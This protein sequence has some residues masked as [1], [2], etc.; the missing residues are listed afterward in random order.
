MRHVRSRP[1]RPDDSPR[2][3]RVQAP[4]RAEWTSTVPAGRRTVGSSRARDHHSG[5]PAL[6]VPQEERA[7]RLDLEDSPTVHDPGRPVY[8][9]Q[10]LEVDRVVGIERER[11]LRPWGHAQDGPVHEAGAE[12]S[13]ARTSLLLPRGLDRDHALSSVPRDPLSGSP[14]FSTSY[15]HRSSDNARR[16]PRLRHGF[17]LEGTRTRTGRVRKLRELSLPSRCSSLWRRGRE[18]SV[19]SRC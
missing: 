4:N 14:R 7:P 16:R 15:L 11:E 2:R 18:P 5:E 17:R 1:A 10:P 9:P 3:R 19:G 12:L 6:G 13:F 8:G